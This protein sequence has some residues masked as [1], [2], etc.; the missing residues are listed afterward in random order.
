MLL[1]FMMNFVGYPIVGALLAHVAKDI[2]GIDQS[3]LG[4]LIASFSGGALTGSIILSVMGGRL[5]AARS[6]LI[7]ATIWFTF[8]LVFAWITTPVPGE[9]V[10]FLAGVAQS[11]CMIPMAVMLLRVSAPEFRGRVMGVRMLAVYGLPL[12][13]LL[14]GPLVERFGFAATGT[15]FSVAGIAFALWVAIRWRKELWRKDAPV[16]Q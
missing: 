1:A 6:M 3:G 15:A 8:D 2:Y 14:S 11:F 5:P 12:G 10:L 13:L 9:I 16:N 7:G 4:W